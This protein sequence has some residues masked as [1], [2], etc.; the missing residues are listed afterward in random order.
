MKAFPFRMTA[1]ALRSRWARARYRKPTP[2]GEPRAKRRSTPCR[3]APANSPGN[4]VV[5][6]QRAPSSLL[7]LLAGGLDWVYISTSSSH[8]NE[9]CR[10]E[11]SLGAL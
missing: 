6:L 9:A 11:R 10:I 5:E 8:P 3:A 4:T 7:P 2:A 1:T